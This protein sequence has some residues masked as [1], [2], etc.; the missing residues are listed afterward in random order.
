MP[1]L[2]GIFSRRSRFFELLEGSAA[3]AAES[4][5]I[6]GRLTVQIGKG[7]VGKERAELDRARR[8]HQRL[9]QETTEA[10]T[11]VFLPPLRRPDIEALSSAL[12]KITKNCEKIGD[13]L[14]YGP[15]G[16]E[17]SAIGTQLALLQ[18]ASA[19]VAQM[20]LELRRRCHGE[21]VRDLNERLQAI[22]SEA[23][24]VMSEQLRELY[25][26]R[27]IDARNVIFWKDLYELLERGIDRCRDAGYLVF[28]IVLRHS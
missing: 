16:R 5:T 8:E 17:L 26:G 7:A 4:A 13:R 28:H 6:L 9:S 24:Q 20:V 22:E 19:I 12:Y 27:E 25:T 18:Q 1:S 23:D 11:K 3:H 2:P 14:S 15:R 10:L 21:L